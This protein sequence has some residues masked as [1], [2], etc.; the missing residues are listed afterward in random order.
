MAWTNAVTETVNGN[1][2]NRQAKL[3]AWNDA[4]AAL[5]KAQELERSLRAEVI[6]IFSDVNETVLTSGTENVN[7]PGGKLKIERSIEY[8]LGRTINDKVV[9]DNDEVDKILDMIEKSQEGG[10]VIAERLVSWKPEISV[11]EYKLLTPAQKA[12]VDRYLVTKQGSTSVKFE[13]T[14]A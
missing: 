13:P 2:S 14:Q 8:K 5:A 4:K 1:L 3:N 10:N 6:S 12:I 11:R 7:V 9:C